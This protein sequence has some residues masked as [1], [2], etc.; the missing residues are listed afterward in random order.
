MTQEID[1]THILDELQWRGLLHQT[2]AGE[3]LRAHLASPGRVGYC[4][5]DPTRD[6]LTIGNFIPI[7]L[8]M[9]WQRAGHA[10]IALMGGG[11]G[12][13]GDPSGKDA[14][15]VLLDREQVEANIAGQRR[16]MER[17]LDFD[18]PCAARMVNNI[19]W[20][21]PL[22]FLEVLRDVGKHFSV[23]A[24]IQ[25]DSVRERLKNRDQGISYTEFS[26]MILQA[27]DFLHLR[28]TANCTV[29]IAGSDQY[30][31]TVAGIDLIR[32]KM[33]D[34]PE[35][36]PRAWG[37]T[38]PL[39]TGRDGKKIGKTEAGAVWLSADRTSPYRLYQFWL[40][41]DD[42]DAENFLKWYT[43]LPREEI[44]TVV[45][46]HQKAAHLRVAQQRLA[47]EFT[48]L[49]HGP[50]ELH[51]AQQASQ[52]LF[53]GDVRELDAALLDE[54]CADVP[55]SEHPRAQL[56]GQGL[57]LVQ[58][59]PETSLASSRREARQFLSS[60]AVMINGQRLAKEE[61]LERCLGT[62]DLL[63]GRTILLK[64]GKKRW[65]ATRWD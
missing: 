33:Q 57:P 8:L 45:A 30:G 46:E 52:A 27:Y 19:D 54:V 58:F 3:E 15:R 59:L 41:V 50:E 2:T 20:L 12:L 4:G 22:G 35:D 64:R 1:D 55:S 14:E 48:R 40:N 6:S 37:I 61:A 28:R 65:H 31:N 10:P 16:I 7:K 62:A 34:E 38:A 53:G 60:G 56:G 13:I 17:L 36:M 26:Y 21:E 18:G 23:N 9:H 44:A 29:Q 32:R 49:L 11:T 39:V 5:F 25:K 43:F 24:M 47:E 63:H 42:H 51:R